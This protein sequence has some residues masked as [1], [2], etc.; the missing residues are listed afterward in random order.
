MKFILKQGAGKTETTK[1]ILRYL[2]AMASSSG[3]SRDADRS[4][5]LAHKVLESN[6]LL[7]VYRLLFLLLYVQQF[8]HLVPKAFGNART[9][10]N[11]N[12]SRFGKFMEIWYLQ[13]FLIYLTTQN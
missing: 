13:T 2:A 11:D 5:V 7:E 8:D 6:P 1:Y 4:S 10:F 12:S 9:R 3:S